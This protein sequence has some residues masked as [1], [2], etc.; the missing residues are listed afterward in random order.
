[1]SDA[2]LDAAKS[3][4]ARIVK[5]LGGRGVFGVELMVRGDEV[6]FCDVTTR[7]YESGLVTL[8]TQ[9][10]SGFELQ[11]RAV[12]GLATDTIM[13][14]PGAARVLYAGH[15]PTTDVKP[16]MAG[17]LVDALS[18]PESDIRVFAHHEAEAPRR[19]GVALATAPDVSTARNRARQISAALRPLW[20]S[21]PRSS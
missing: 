15:E 7:P 6:Y 17:A 1:M 16:G 19:L 5:A 2:A 11:A 20:A 10:L 8:R 9:R 12:L 21:S 4:A 3:I 14:S 18:V 13:I